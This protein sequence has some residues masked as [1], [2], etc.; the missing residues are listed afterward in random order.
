PDHRRLLEEWMQ[1]YRPTDLFDE[2]G[3]PRE[4][5]LARTPAGARR[6]SANP[7]TN[8]GLLT[9]PLDM[10]DFRDYEIPVENPGHTRGESTRAMGRLLRDVMQKNAEQANFRLFGPDETASN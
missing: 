9:R 10:P 4:W 6:M 3:A 2:N 5:L 8:G 1:G 7:H